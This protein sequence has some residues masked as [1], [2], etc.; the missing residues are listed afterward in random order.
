MVKKYND[1]KGARY[2]KLTIIKT[3][4]KETTTKR[5]RKFALCKCDCGN[6]TEVRFDCMTNNNTQSCG[7]MNSV[8]K[9]KPNSSKKHKLYRIYWGIKERCYNNKN[10]G[11]KYYGERGITMCDEWNRYENFFSWSLQHGYKDGLQ[12]DRIDT[13]RNYSPDN[14]RWVTP[15]TNNYNKRNNI[16]VLYKDGW[17]TIQYIANKDGISWNKAYYRYITKGKKPVKYLYGG[18]RIGGKSN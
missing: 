11:Y 15:S 9:C 1:E 3:Y 10:K 6:L 17:K 8:D 2:G 12:L 5:K 14:C 7:C 16:L 4:Y 18:G 13:N